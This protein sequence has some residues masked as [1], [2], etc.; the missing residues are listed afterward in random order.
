[1]R[2]APVSPHAVH[3]PRRVGS[4]AV[5]AAVLGERG[6]G[7]GSI[8]ELASSMSRSF[9]LERLDDAAQVACDFPD[10]VRALSAWLDADR[11]RTGAA[12]R[13]YLDER[14]NGAARRFFSCRSH[15][16]HLLRSVAPTKLVDG[17]WLFGLLR[18][19]DD[20]RLAPLIRIYLEELG[21]GSAAQ[22]HVAIY[23]RLL[24]ANGCDGPQALIDGHYTQGAIQLSLAHHANEF[25]PEVI[26]FNLGYEQL[27]LH[28]PITAHELAEL[29][30]DPTYFT[31]HVSVDNASTGHAR[32][33]FDALVDMLPKGGG[34]AE[35]MR[36]VALGY[37]LN[38]LGIGTVEAVESFDLERE[39]VEVLAAKAEV[40]ADL[41]SDRCR[42]RGRSVTAWLADRGEA[43]ALLACLASSGWIR[44]GHDPEE[45]RFWRLLH[46][47]RAPM[48]GVFSGYE[49]QLLRDWIAAGSSANSDARSRA[50]SSSAKSAPRPALASPALRR[51]LAGLQTTEDAPPDEDADCRA[52]EGR[53]LA[54]SSKREAM[55]LLHGHLSPANH[56]KPA[57]LLATRLYAGVFDGRV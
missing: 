49:D 11:E 26:G 57:G 5:Y 22:N 29:D 44:R 24:A 20:V 19:W 41:H 27:P 1:M 31:L 17:A 43:P 34:E 30:V 23:R 28:L 9:L 46:D 7:L 15:A 32:K 42:I 50:V 55:A 35:F 45:S 18:C 21:C 14:R 10:D 4:R 47:E 39:L 25:L 38:H 8:D 53:L 6:E 16:L 54:A 33:A 48:F 56:Y 37:R 12:Y 40:G 13:H 2:S 52:L 51:H 3:P 36:R